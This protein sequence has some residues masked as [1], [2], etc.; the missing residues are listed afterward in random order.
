MSN[1]GQDFDFKYETHGSGA[2]ILCIHGF[3]G[4]MYTWKGLV[5]RLAE[6]HKLYLIDL[7]GFGDSPKPIDRNY[8][9]NDHAELIH[10]FIVRHDLRDVTLMGHS[11]GG[12]VTLFTT[13]RLLREDRHRLASLVLINSVAYPQK[14][15]TFMRLLRTPLIGR[16]GLLLIPGSR[17]T[18]RV[19]RLGYYDRRKITDDLISVYSKP[20]GSAG[21]KHALIQTARQILPA[22]LDATSLGYETISVPTLILL[23]MNDRIVPHDVGLRLSR[24][25]KGARLEIIERCGHNLPEECPEEAGKVI[26]QFLEGL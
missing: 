15:P 1:S 22:N 4:N 9:I 18:K 10:K 2:P 16:L 19:L 11:F 24:A 13:L 6:K 17:N 21:G 25:I 3:G 20:L 23:G 7:K 26:S 8:S 12:A 5:P 14:L